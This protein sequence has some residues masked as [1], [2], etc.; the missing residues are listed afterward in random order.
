MDRANPTQSSGLVTPANNPHRMQPD[1]A[2]DDMGLVDIETIN[3]AHL[4]RVVIHV[5]WFK[6]GLYS[7]VF[8]LLVFQFD[9]KP[10]W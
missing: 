3:V 9:D 10:W 5:A 8:L 1:I 7:I 6:Y 4:F 2:A